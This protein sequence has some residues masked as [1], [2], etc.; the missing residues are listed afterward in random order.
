[1]FLIWRGWGILLPL[2]VLVG[3][4]IGLF[5]CVGLLG[6]QSGLEPV[7]IALCATVAAY[8][9]VTLLDR[10]DKGKLVID[11]ETGEEMLLKRGDSLF[12]IPV[13]FWFYLLVL[14]TIITLGI[15]IFSRFAA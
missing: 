5:V 3:A 15:S 9:V 10:T 2:G 4:L 11:A 8:G 13:R 7:I 12:F 1:M 14:I 6:P